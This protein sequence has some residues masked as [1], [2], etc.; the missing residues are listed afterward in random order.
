MSLSVGIQLRSSV[1]HTQVVV[2]RAPSAECA[3][4]C[5]GHPLMPLDSEAESQLVVVA[6]HEGGTQ[7]GKRYT[8]L[9]LGLELLCT[10]SG[11][12]SLAVDGRPLELKSA[13]PLPASD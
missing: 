4:T 6:G 7:I 3:V 5:G 2:I 12:A 10:K 9:E 8:D 1:D 11:T 13:K